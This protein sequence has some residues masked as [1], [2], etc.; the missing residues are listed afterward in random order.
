MTQVKAQQ[1]KVGGSSAAA[2]ALAL[3]K[4]FPKQA[5]EIVKV[6]SA[7][8]TSASMKRK[9]VRVQKALEAMRKEGAR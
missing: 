8:A 6:M 5:E 7:A 3:N 4:S 2:V 9:L 1:P